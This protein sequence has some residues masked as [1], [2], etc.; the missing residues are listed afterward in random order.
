MSFDQKVLSN[1]ITLQKVIIFWWLCRTGNPGYAH[2][3]YR[4]ITRVCVFP[5][6]YD[7][8]RFGMCDLERISTQVSTMFGFFV[9]GPD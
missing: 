5:R 2:N 9:C 1:F 8:R 4:V 7:H 6:S 3:C